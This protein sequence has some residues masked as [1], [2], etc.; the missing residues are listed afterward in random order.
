MQDEL[1]A[2][3]LKGKFKFPQEKRRWLKKQSQLWQRK[4]QQNV[5]LNLGRGYSDFD[6]D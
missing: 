4:S 6:A 3:K 5:D 2:P 1:F